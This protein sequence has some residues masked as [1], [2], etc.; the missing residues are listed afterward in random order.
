MKDV[1][2]IRHVETVSDDWEMDKVLVSLVYIW[3][4]FYW[5]REINL[6]NY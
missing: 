3:G 5:G 6:H 4:Y 1:N 2:E